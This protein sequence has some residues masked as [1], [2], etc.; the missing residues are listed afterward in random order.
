MTFEGALRSSSCPSLSPSLWKVLYN[1]VNQF[2]EQNLDH[3]LGV[4][5]E[6]V[7]DV[8]HAKLKRPYSGSQHLYV[9]LRRRGIDDDVLSSISPAEICN[10][11]VI[12]CNIFKS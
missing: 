2:L 8:A 12:I 11:F 5:A 7:T 9:F 10:M 4:Y 1:H 3:G 6:Q